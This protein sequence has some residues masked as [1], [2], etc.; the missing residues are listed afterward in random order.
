MADE[1]SFAEALAKLGDVKTINLR[2]NSPG[3]SA[4]SGVAIYNQLK[5]HP[6]RIEVD[7]DGLAASIASVIA[8][9]GDE[10][11]MGEGAQM[12][13]H[14][15]SSFSWGNADAMRRQADLL[16]QISSD[17]AEIYARR[18]GRTA[19]EIRDL[20][21]A[22]TWFTA[23]QAVEHKLAD[24]VSAEEVTAHLSPEIAARFKHPPKQLLAPREVIDMAKQRG[25]AESLVAR[26][27]VYQRK[28]PVQ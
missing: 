16:D 8:M 28:E 6:A 20:M 15:A 10:V 27:A 5:R 4:F 19:T 22:E 9:A 13:I 17:L 7:V 26:A 3:G 1:K 14:D 12:M 18:T 23:K 11:R 24:A 25:K 21:R 2:I